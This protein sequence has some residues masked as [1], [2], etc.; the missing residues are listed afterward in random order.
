MTHFEDMAA[1]GREIIVRIKKWDDWD[2][3]LETEYEGEELVDIIED[4]M[5]KNTVKGRFNL[6]DATENMML[7]E[8]VRIP[9]Y[10]ANGNATDARRFVKGL[11]K[12]LKK[13]PYLIVNKLMMKGLGR[14]TIVLGGK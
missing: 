14:A 13:E 8:Q 1:N 4:W 11:S 3:D 2:E 10:D 6:S 7:F 5:V 12:M 9:L